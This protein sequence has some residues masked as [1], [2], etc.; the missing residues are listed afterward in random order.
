MKLTAISC[1]EYLDDTDKIIRLKYDIEKYFKNFIKYLPY[2]D[3]VV[4]IKWKNEKIIVIEINH[5]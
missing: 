3:A 1:D 2:N 5:F 4:D